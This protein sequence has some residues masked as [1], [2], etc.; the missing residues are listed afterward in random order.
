MSFDAKFLAWL[1][2]SYQRH[3]W[4]RIVERWEEGYV[5]VYCDPNVFYSRLDLLCFVCWLGNRRRLDWEK[6][7]LDE[8]F[9]DGLG[10]SIRPCS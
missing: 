3:G 8:V 6:A 4:R 5:G 9:P 2:H 10:L 7:W 1:Y